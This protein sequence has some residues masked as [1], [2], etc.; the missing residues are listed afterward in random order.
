M[1]AENQQ[2]EIERLLRGAYDA[3]P[4]RAEFVES[5]RRQSEDALRAGPAGRT[6]P[7]PAEKG[8]P[9]KR[10]RPLRNSALGLAAIAAVVLLCLLP[11]L[12][13]TRHGWADVVQA[14]RTRPW[15]HAT[16]ALPDGRTGELWY[17]PVHE[18][19]AHRHGGVVR[20][21]DHRLGL[22]YSYDAEKELLIRWVEVRG[23]AKEES[24]QFWGTFE[25][26]FGGHE[27]LES[28]FRTAEVVEQQRRRVASEGKTWVEYELLL[29]MAAT[30]ARVVFRVD[31][32][33]L[34]PESMKLVAIDEETAE[35]TFRFD[36]PEEGPADVY[37]LGV[38]RDAKHVDRVPKGDVA[39]LI[40]S[41]EARRRRFPDSYYA[42]TIHTSM[43]GDNP[44]RGW[45][46]FNHFWRKSN[47]WRLEQCSPGGRKARE[48]IL[49]FREAKPPA[50]GEDLSAWRKEWLKDFRFD[51]VAVCDGEKIY[52]NT[53][54]SDEPKWEVYQRVDAYTA[55]R[56]F[57]FASNC[58]PEKQAYPGLQ[59]PSEQYAVELIEEPTEG[60][61]GTVLYQVE[62]TVKS[63]GGDSW[64][65]Y[66]Y[67]IDPARGYVTLRYEL[68]ASDGEP[69]IYVKEGLRQSPN[70]I[71]Y[72][73]VVRWKNRG[74]EQED[75]EGRADQVWHLYVDFGAELPDAL[76]KPADRPDD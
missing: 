14:V 66:R 47:K 65:L 61:P 4:P 22:V 7:A 57:P 12:V 25:A 43:P 72:P 3:R 28:P 30:R 31:P 24:R 29:E 26:I 48:A 38:P 53:G 67:W 13:E 37:A 2:D 36:Y 44:L 69:S 11:W 34:L 16:V 20:F 70:G 5:L 8:H 68:V 64:K 71:W 62:P 59:R 19:S 52:R 18:V 50:P 74:M 56:Y 10:T 35:S 9:P 46:S 33:T 39:R 51:P 41:V 76:F 40:E 27:K 21:C 23:R 32:E 6:G 1:T 75:G 63:A 54:G 58:V 17:S 60:P 15:V 73:T 55:G 45:V 42:I 49:H